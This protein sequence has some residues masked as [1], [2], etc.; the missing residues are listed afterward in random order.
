MVPSPY[1]LEGRL[2][3]E[4][5]VTLSLWT[6]LLSVIMYNDVIS[7]FVPSVSIDELEFMYDNWWVGGLL[8]YPRFR[9]TCK[10]RWGTD[11]KE[12]EQ[13]YR[14]LV[15]CSIFD[16]DPLRELIMSLVDDVG[17]ADDMK[18]HLKTNAND[19]VRAYR[20][21]AYQPL[22]HFTIQNGGIE[23]VR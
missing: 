22:T 13:Y 5:D 8:H 23:H 20:V 11:D 17:D 15:E 2:G 6:R 1:V 12:D 21:R 14:W 7:H 4:P 9:K 10:E 3:T 19:M 18:T 16:D